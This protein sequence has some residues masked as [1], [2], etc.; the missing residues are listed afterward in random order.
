MDFNNVSK[1]IKIAP[2]LAGY[3]QQIRREIEIAYTGSKTMRGKN[4]G[5]GKGDE[6]RYC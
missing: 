4:S 2:T 3:E 6:R 5:L 1:K